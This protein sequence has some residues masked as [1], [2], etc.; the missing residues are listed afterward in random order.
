LTYFTREVLRIDNPA[1]VNFLKVAKEDIKFDDII[2]K[3]GTDI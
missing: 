3:K 1:S 2:I